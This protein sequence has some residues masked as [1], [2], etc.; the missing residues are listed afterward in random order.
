MGPIEL[1]GP[2]LQVGCNC[3]FSYRDKEAMPH[4]GVVKTLKPDMAG[5]ESLLPLLLFP[6][7]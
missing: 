1:G 3:V 5:F 6:Q 4:S 7:L 2:H